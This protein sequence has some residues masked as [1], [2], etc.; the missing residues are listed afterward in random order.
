MD[1]G[2]EQETVYAQDQGERDCIRA[3]RNPLEVAR[4]KDPGFC[5]SVVTE[6][7]PAF[8]GTPTHAK[9]YRSLTMTS[10]SAFE[11]AANNLR[12][13]RLCPWHLQ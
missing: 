8:P 12:A 13:L 10:M 7:R 9:D 3:K 11:T 4:S 2:R 5:R 6:L 1:P